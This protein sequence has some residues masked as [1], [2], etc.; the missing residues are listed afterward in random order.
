MIEEILY[1]SAPKGLKPGSQG[2]CTVNST[3]GMAQTTAERLET[4]SGYRHA[5]AITDPRAALNP[6]NYSHVT[7][8]L[9][10]RPTHVL[11]RI[12]NAGQDYTGRSNKLA[13]HLAFEQ[14]SSWPAGPA[15]MLQA[16]DVMV[17][18]WDGTLRTFAPRTLTLPPPPSQIQLSAWNQCT[19]DHGWA[20]YV[21]EQLLQQPQPLHVIFAPGTSTLDLVREV[22]DLLPPARRWEITFSTYFT[23]LPAGVDCRLRFVLDETP[24]AIALRHDARSQVLDLTQ[25]LPPAQGGALVTTARTGVIQTALAELPPPNP[26]SPARQASSRT[27]PQA[28]PALASLTAPGL[29]ASP[30]RSLVPELAAQPLFP[31][32]P[33][34]PH[35]RKRWSP[36]LISSAVTLLLLAPIVGYF[37]WY[38]KLI[39][40]SSSQQSSATDPATNSSTPLF[41]NLGNSPE[42]PTKQ[43]RGTGTEIPK[44]TLIAS[45]ADTADAIPTPPAAPA[46]TSTE[47]NATAATAAPSSPMATASANPSPPSPDAVGPSPTPTPEPAVVTEEQPAPPTKPGPFDLITTTVATMPEKV[48]LWDWKEPNASEKTAP[49]PLSL[50]GLEPKLEIIPWAPFNTHLE[51]SSAANS[52]QIQI[53]PKADS[54]GTW[55]VAATDEQKEIPVG[56]IALKPADPATTPA[57]THVLEFQWAENPEE[58]IVCIARWCPLELKTEGGDVYCALTPMEKLDQISLTQFLKEG[59]SEAIALNHQKFGQIGLGGLE[60]PRFGIEIHCD[61]AP[62]QRIETSAA[63]AIDLRLT[64]TEGG[65]FQVAEASSTDQPG[66]LVTIRLKSDARKDSEATSLKIEA[67]LTAAIPKTGLRQADQPARKKVEHPRAVAELLKLKPNESVSTETLQDAQTQLSSFADNIT[68]TITEDMSQT[69][70]GKYYRDAADICI[71]LHEKRLPTL[72]KTLYAR[73]QQ[74]QQ[75]LDQVPKQPNPNPEEEK[76]RQQKLQSLQNQI[77]QLTATITATESL[78]TAVAAQQKWFTTN[79]EPHLKLLNDQLAWLRAARLR[80]V[81]F[82]NFPDPALA[83]NSTRGRVR[84]MEVSIS[85]TPEASR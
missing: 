7:L 85:D 65:G 74:K 30:P 10:G 1:T 75:E 76:E 2:F 64:P 82:A 42:P 83:P 72:K 68:I 78:L 50:S 39:D 26:A 54:P 52:L 49:L 8:R 81:F 11:S 51:R 37:A 13:H 46:A 67:A 33:E 12:A 69:S 29:P 70:I 44:E 18:V 27:L 62:S 20:G 6:V 5:F 14:T 32:S 16:P 84:L 58:A 79:R 59:Y 34:L 45:A 21:A 47:P 35:S 28:P 57:A 77:N 36:V 38:T 31:P 71:K 56:Q 25:P 24:E 4:L 41:E 40:R 43:S 3:I 23:R 19:G 17:A 48:I 9:G 15:R 61:T 55:D 80:I 53:Q 60:D 66:S 22:L 63:A 73:R